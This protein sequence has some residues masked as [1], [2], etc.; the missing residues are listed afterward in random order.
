LKANDRRVLVITVIGFALRLTFLGRQSLWYDEAFSL[1][2][3]RADWPVFWAALL[4]DGVHPPGYYLLVREGLALFGNG[5]FAL[6][7]SSVL[8]GTLAVPLLYQL[9]CI[10]GGRRWGLVAGLL[11]ALNPFALWYAQ[12]ARMYSL[13]LCLSIA[14]GYTFWRLVTR[15]D[16]RHWLWLTLVSALSFV[17][18]YF[19][20]LFS[21]VQFVYLVAS[22]RRNYRVLRW[23]VASQVAAFL[24]FLPWAAAIVTREG[25]NFGIGWIHPPTL[26]DVPLT[27][28]NLAFALSDP[29]RP[30]TWAALALVVGA[31]AAGLL[32]G[33]KRSMLHAPR[34]APSSP[35]SLLPTPYSLLLIWLL[36]P[37]VFTWLFSLRLP[38]YVDRFLIICLPPLLLLGSTLSLSSSWGARGTMTVLIMVSAVASFR[39]WVDPDLT[40][41][42][43]R[44]AAAYVQSLEEPGDILIMRDL[45]ISIPF[46]HY[47]QGA[48]ELQVA[49]V[50]QQTRPLDD[51]S[52][53]YERL[54]LVYRR[55]FEATHALAGSGSFNWQADQDLVIH[56]WLVSHASALAQEVTFPGVYVV[57]Y[58]LSSDDLPEVED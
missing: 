29:T 9:G 51:L 2:V 14:G 16:T 37:I 24:L 57:L 42:D 10:L 40:K 39:L 15:P 26:L 46:G 17:V 32:A 54:W 21:L 49:S 30:W 23:W 33:A 38:L 5:E 22:L 35:Y 8:A 43:W 34:S 53:G 28:S 56:D 4:S 45:Q 41:E 19:A 18:H 47:Y 58:Q 55:P 25:R 50:N 52:R 6:R 11:L 7:F 12:E 48:L 13:T 20:F 3:A 27:L 31:V 44:T 36:G 1:A